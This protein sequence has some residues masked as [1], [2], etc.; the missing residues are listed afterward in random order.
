MDKVI[1]KCKISDWGCVYHACMS[2]DC[3][4]KN[5]LNSN[6]SWGPGNCEKSKIKFWKPNLLQRLLYKL[7]IQKDPR[8]NG[9]KNQ[10]LLDDEAGCFPY[11]EL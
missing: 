1:V 3:Q 10:F 8:Y 2:D 7:R 11:N 9:K 5:V 6:V 4:I